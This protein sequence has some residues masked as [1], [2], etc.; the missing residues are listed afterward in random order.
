MLSAITFTPLLGAI[1]ILFLPNDGIIKRFA[2][3]W[4]LIPLVL[5]T[6]AWVIFPTW[7]GFSMLG[8]GCGADV[9]FASQSYYLGECANW[10]PAL[11]VQYHLGVDGISMPLIWL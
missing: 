5:A 4:S 6:V 8:S 1:I 9:T 3:V 11:G 2:I 7:P 10:I